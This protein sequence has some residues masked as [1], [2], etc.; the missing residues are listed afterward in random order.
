MADYRVYVVTPG[1]ELG[2]FNEIVVA[3]DDAAIAFARRIRPYDDLEVWSGDRKV[4]SL[5]IGVAVKAPH[6]SGRGI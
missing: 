6:M 4:A 2:S 5:P 1:G 3:N